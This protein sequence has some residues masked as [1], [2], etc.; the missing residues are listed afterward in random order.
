[1]APKS[2]SS[3]D[4]NSAAADDPE[5]AKKLAPAAQSTGPVAA[6][7]AAASPSDDA[8]EEDEDDELEIEDKDEDEKRETGDD[9]D[10]EA[11]VVFTAKE[12]AGA[13]ATVYG[14]IKPFLIKNKKPL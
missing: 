4:Q 13:L 9:E 5:L 11:L 2:P 10:D 3:D 14:F 12:A 8:D 7:K 6:G 1:M